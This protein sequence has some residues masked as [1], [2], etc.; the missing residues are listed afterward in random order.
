MTYFHD[1][2]YGRHFDET[3]F[4]CLEN[5]AKPEKEI[6]HIILKKLQLEPHETIFIDDKPEYIDG[7]TKV[8]INGI[9]FQ[10]IEQVKKELNDLG[11]KTN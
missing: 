1:N 8:G 4:S 5:T 7:A 11:I 10:D 3:V 9:V 2:N 6:Y